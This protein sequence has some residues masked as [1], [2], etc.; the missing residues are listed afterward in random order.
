M[1]Y[2]AGGFGVGIANSRQIFYHLAISLSFT[3]YKFY[4]V[5]SVDMIIGTC[6]DVKNNLRSQFSPSTTGSRDCA[7]VLRLLYDFTY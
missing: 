4:F 3:Y 1:I 2:N 6:T 7:Q 5:I